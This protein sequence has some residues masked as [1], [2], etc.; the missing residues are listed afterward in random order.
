MTWRQMAE[1]S[2]QV[3]EVLLRAGHFRGSVSRSYYAAYCATTG[4][5]VQNVTSFPFGWNNPPHQSVSRYVQ[6]NLS[7]PQT[8]KNAVETNIT[9][10]RL[11]R[12]DADC[13]PAK[14]IDELT[15]RDCVRLSAGVLQLL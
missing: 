4:R 3:A 12:E 7:L 2:L 11:F 6:N 9:L 10:L 1:D 5:I 15:A 8:V 14:T 13:R